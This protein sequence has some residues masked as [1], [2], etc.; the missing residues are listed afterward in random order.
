MEEL[1]NLGFKEN[2][3][4]SYG[5]RGALRVSFVSRKRCLQIEKS[6]TRDGCLGVRGL[7]FV[8]F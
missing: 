3:L 4:F 6:G 5:K 8:R 2:T 7:E 1:S